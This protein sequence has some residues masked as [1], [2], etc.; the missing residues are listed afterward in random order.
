MAPQSLLVSDRTSSRGIESDSLIYV[1]GP[2]DPFVPP[3]ET[4]AH[5]LR[6]YSVSIGKAWREEEWAY[7]N[8]ILTRLPYKPTGD[9]S[10]HAAAR[11]L[12]EFQ[13]R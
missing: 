4:Q 11:L 2:F 10:S 9:L 13:F 6:R 3:P 8:D 12:G 5:V 1:S 7:V